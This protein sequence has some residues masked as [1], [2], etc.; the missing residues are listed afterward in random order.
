MKIKLKK[1]ILLFAGSM[2]ISCSEDYMKKVEP[3]R[4]K[5]EY[6]RLIYIFCISIVFVFYS[7]KKEPQN[8]F[9]YMMGH[10]KIAEYTSDSP[11]DL[12]GD[13]I[14]HTDILHYED[15]NCGMTYSWIYATFS[16]SNQNAT[17]YMGDI[18]SLVTERYPA[19]SKDCQYP[20]QL[21]Y[22]AQI[23]ADDNFVFYYDQTTED[24]IKGM[25]K[26]AHRQS[27]IYKN[28]TLICRFKKEFYNADY[29]WI[30]ADITAKLKKVSSNLHGY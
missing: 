28:D 22:M 23:L 5:S 18:V 4:Y 8:D 24:E 6:N 15:K 2:L 3:A 20:H 7:C 12:N 17:I 9:K 19:N 26:L 25:V 29:E 30:E 13:G 16:V 11:L 14:A 27:I 10:Y 21:K 1:M